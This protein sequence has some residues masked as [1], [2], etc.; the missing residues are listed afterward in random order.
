MRTVQVRLA[1]ACDQACRFC[2]IARTAEDLSRTEEAVRARIDALA[3][4]AAREPVMLSVTGGEP[5]IH[6]RLFETLRYARARGIGDFCIETHGMRLADPAFADALAKVGARLSFFI[7]LHH[8][9]P[10]VSDLITAT[11]GGQARTLAGIRNALAR[12]MAVRLNCV[13][14]SLNRL[15][16]AAYA[17]FVARDLRGV[18]GVTF[19]YIAPVGAAVDRPDLMPRMSD[20][21]PSLRAALAVCHARGLEAVIPMRCGVPPCVLPGYERLHDACRPDAPPAMLTP[22]RVKAPACRHCVHDARCVGVWKG[23]AERYGVGELIPPPGAG[24]SRGDRSRSYFPGAS[25]AGTGAGGPAAGA[26]VAGGGV[27][28]FGRAPGP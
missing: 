15:D 27:G 5:T 3:T 10:E 24:A 2:S 1:L 25:G 13:V 6:P 16:L 12:E 28:G 11:P 18:D 9:R 17:E 26:P 21:M 22:D 4:E 20:V 8:H 23:Y 14:C 7:S 19:S